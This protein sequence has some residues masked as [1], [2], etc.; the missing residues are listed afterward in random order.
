MNPIKKT[1]LDNSVILVIEANKLGVKRAVHADDKSIKT[2][3]DRSLLGINKTL[4]ECDELDA[5][6]AHIAS[7]SAYARDICLPSPIFHHGSYLLPIPLVLEVNKALK[8]K[9]AALV[10]LVD[11]LCEVYEEK[12]EATRKRLG[13]VADRTDYPSVE[14]VRKAFSVKLSYHALASAEQL[15]QVSPELFESNMREVRQSIQSHQD[16]I[17]KVLTLGMSKV[18]DHLVEVLKPEGDK[19]KV[20]RVTATG[21]VDEFL[22]TFDARNITNNDELAALA[23]KAR[24]ALKGIPVKDLRKSEVIRDRVAT[25]F[26]QIQKTLSTMVEDRPTRKLGFGR[27]L[28]AETATKEVSKGKKKAA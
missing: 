14:E 20:I 17:N 4:L 16:D 7:I 23:E 6:F 9:I 1:Y 11:A 19:K 18:V 12:A 28:V 10:P 15:K 26:E 3:A 2:E 8:G 25:Q 5:V 24:A 27:K 13:P 21:N 22:R